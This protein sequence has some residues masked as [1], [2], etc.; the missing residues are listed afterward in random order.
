LVAL[1]EEISFKKKKLKN[2]AQEITVMSN[3]KHL[4]LRLNLSKS[5]GST[6][7]S[8]IK[9]QDQDSTIRKMR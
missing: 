5:K 1:R 8:I 3:L 6:N 9:I 4:D 7:K 2:Q